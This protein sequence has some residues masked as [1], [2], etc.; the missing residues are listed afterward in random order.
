MDNVTDAA[1]G[2][3]NELHLD[4]F[5][6]DDDDWYIMQCAHEHGLD[7]YEV[8]KRV[9]RRQAAQRLAQP[10]AVPSQGGAG[11]SMLSPAGA[12]A[13]GAGVQWPPGSAGALAYAFYNASIR[14]VREV[15]IATALAALAGV[16]GRNWNTHTGAGLN[17][18]IAFVARSAI[19]KEAIADSIS[20]LVRAIVKRGEAH[21]SSFF[22]FSGMASGQGLI[23]F[24]TDAPFACALH[25]S[26]EFGHDISFMA[27]DKTG[28]HA[29][30]RQHMTR[31]Y[32][33][34]GGTSMAGG[35]NYSNSEN[36][37]VIEGSASYSII[38]ETTPGTF[39]E[40][41]DGKMLADGFMS[42]FVVIDYSGPRPP[43]NKTRAELPQ[44]TVAWFGQ[45]VSHAVQYAMRDPALV[46]PSSE[47]KAA[48]DQF[49]RECDDAINA[50]EDEARRQMWNRAHLN[51]LKVASLLAVADNFMFPAISDAHAR[52]AIDLVKRNIA[53]MTKRLDS[54]D[55]G[56]SDHSRRQK[57]HTCMVD[58]LMKDLP[59]TYAD[60]K[61]WVEMQRELVVPRYYITNRLQSVSVFANHKLGANA[62]IDLALQSLIADGVVQHIAKPR[63]IENY[64]YH[65]DAYRVL[66]SLN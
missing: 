12:E 21:A 22:T 9:R 63:V 10:Q 15:S 5:E 25:I 60:R 53:S 13:T 31:L 44:S 3:D 8:R 47:A 14:P 64:G 35:I 24:M 57:V 30:L 23:K 42:R 45:L 34:S 56:D 39:F 54:G 46:T 55:V 6:H 17:L 59:K 32:S 33:K 26:G 52:W 7:P 36:S 41:L 19:G 61:G 18:Y 38:G 37:V 62:A 43:A 20:A 1:G 11:G 2:S 16:C 58:Y 66:G 51:A 28:P 27:A 40:A 49:D 48:F 4:Q 50:T 29:T 65:G